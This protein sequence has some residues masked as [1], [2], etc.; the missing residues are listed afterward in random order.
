MSPARV[1]IVE[2]NPANLAPMEYLLRAFGYTVLTARDGDEGIAVARRERP[3]LILMDLQM[4]KVTG[5]QA[6]KQLR[7]D[8]TLAAPIVAVMAFAMVGDRDRV[9]AEGF[10]GYISKPIDP[11]TFVAQLEAFLPKL[12]RSRGQVPPS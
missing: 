7:S 10:D 12:L 8:P 5:S 3:D 6:A 2:D 11:E 1:L 4:P 9:L